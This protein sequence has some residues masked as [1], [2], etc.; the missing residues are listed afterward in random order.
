MSG[1]DITVTRDG[2]FWLIEIP[3]LDGAT[4][5][6]RLS[7]VDEM[8]IDYIAE[9]TGEQPATIDLVRTVIPAPP[10]ASTS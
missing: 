9:V 3:A 2:K 10:A 4:Q 1:Y 6:R 7:E 8:A 5:A